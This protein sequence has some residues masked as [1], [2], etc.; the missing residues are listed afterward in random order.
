MDPR[1]QKAALRNAIKER[2]TRL[3][4]KDRSAETR[5]LCKRILEELPA[6]PITL[7]AYSPLSDEAD[8]L[9][10]IGELFKRGDTV[11]LPAHE[12]GK[13]IFRTATSLDDLVPGDFAIPEP[14]HSSQQPEPAAIRVV[15]VPGR[16]FDRK[17]NRLGRGNGGYDVWIRKQRKENPETQFWGVALEC[18]IVQEI[19][20]EAHDAHVDAIVTARGFRRREVQNSPKASAD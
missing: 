4:P 19:P 15:L 14:P 5:S 8:I 7:C 2:L 10:L 1:E 17:G 9:A 13:L 18:Q 16:A 3:S 11:C 6:A 12:V 20:V